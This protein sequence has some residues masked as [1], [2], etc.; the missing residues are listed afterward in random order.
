MPN[1]E[2]GVMRYPRQFVK[3]F[4]GGGI[5]VSQFK[6]RWRELVLS[7]TNATWVCEGFRTDVSFLP[8]LNGL[9]LYTDV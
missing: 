3:D 8:K 2:T 7:G 1:K 9:D 4:V 5:Q 6:R